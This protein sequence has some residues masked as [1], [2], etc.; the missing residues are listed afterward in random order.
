[1]D[2][3]KLFEGLD[4][5]IDAMLADAETKNTTQ[6]Q[7]SESSDFS[8]L[9]AEG[10]GTPSEFD[11]LFTESKV[12]EDENLDID[13]EAEKIEEGTIMK[14]DKKAQ[15]KKQISVTAI[16]IAKEEAP[17][18]YAKYKSAQAKKVQL[19]EL[20]IKKFKSKAIAKI[21]AGS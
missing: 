10:T 6:T 15:L 2:L 14:L 11:A 17:G 4:S 13:A 20:M 16:Q 19:E 21:K 18:V 5:E 7:V 12:D 3:D 8:A 9:F 1:M